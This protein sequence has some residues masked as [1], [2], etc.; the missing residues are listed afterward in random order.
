MSSKY[1]TILLTSLIL[2]LFSTSLFA[3]PPTDEVIQRLKDE[4]RFDE[5]VQSM[6]E[7]RAKGV[8]AGLADDGKGQ[9]SFA[10]SPNSTFRVLVILIDFSNKP[11]TAG[12]TAGSTA[13]FDSLLFSD[14][15]NPTGSMKEFY[16]ENSYGNFVLEGDVTGWYTAAETSD[17]YTNFCDGSRG[18]GS[19]PNNARKL[20]EEA[21]DAADANVDFSLY[22]NDGNGY[23]DG[24]FVVHSGTGYEESGNN[25]EIHSHQW[26]INPRYKDGVYITTYSIE[27]EESPS[28]QGLVPIGVFCHEFGHVLGL[29]DLYDTDYSSS[30]A[31]KWALMA[32]GSYNGQSRTPSQ[33][34]AWSKYRLGWLNLINL[35]SNQTDVEIPAVE[36][37]PVAYRLWKN[38]Q[39]GNE[40]F[41]VEN[42]QRTGFDEF[43]PSSGLLIWHIDESVG[44]NTNDW[45]PKVMLEQADGK[46][47]LQNGSNSGDGADAFP[48]GGYAPNFH[49]KTNPGSKSYLN[50][51]SQVAA[52]NISSP[53]SIM[54][55][56]LDVSWSRPYLY[57]TGHSFSDV[58]GGDGDGFLEAGETI[59]LTLTIGN[60]W[61]NAAAATLDMTIDDGTINITNGSVSLGTIPSGGS[62]NNNGLPLVFEIPPDYTP[63]IDS[64][65]LTVTSDGGASVNVLALEE[66]VGRPAVLL[67]DD[68]NN[69]NINTFYS[70]PLYG[71]RVPYDMWVKYSSGSPTLADLVKYD[72]VIWFT[73]DY[74]ANP[75]TA[76]DVTVLEDF[77]DGGGSLF[78]SGQGIAPE[79]STSYPTFLS[80][81]LKASYLSTSFIPILTPHAGT[82]VFNGLNILS[83]TG[84]GGASNQTNPDHV[85][86]VNGGTPE[87]LYY[88]GSDLAAVSYSGAHK[89]M[90]FSFGFEAIV[91]GDYRFAERDTVYYRIIDFLGVSTSTGYPE[92]ATLEVGPGT[93]MNLTDHTP[94]IAWPYFDAGGAPQQEYHVQVG[95]DTDWSIAEMW[96]HGPI[97]G[98]DTNVVYS[99][100]TLND[101]QTYQV[102]VRAFNGTQWSNWKS[103]QFRMNSVP[104]LPTG[105][106]PGNLTA[107]TSATPIL[108]VQNAFDNEFDDL[109]YDYEVYDDEL[110]TSLV[111]QVTGRPEGA[112]Q[113][114]WTV[115]TTLTENV[116]YYWRARANDGYEDG[117]WSAAASFWV[118]AVNQPPAAFD[119][120]APADSVMMTEDL[121]TYRWSRSSD[122]DLYD[123]LTY[124]LIIANNPAFTAA[125]TI[126]GLNDSVYT[127]SDSITAGL[128][129]YWKVLAVDKFGGVTQSSRVFM[130]S[131]LVPGDA[132]LDGAVDVG[133]AVV[134]INYVFRGGAEPASMTG[135]DVNLDCSVDVGDAVYLINYIFRDGPP[136]HPG[137]A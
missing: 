47:D 96:D 110:L 53:D 8:D 12:W 13:N 129:Y 52:W 100:L 61:K 121:V 60:D 67:V 6:A 92:V 136:P 124:R 71:K 5:F 7:A 127:S 81:Y 16:I 26:S 2:M 59:E 44:G 69:D 27:P 24:I 133:D 126:S 94:N 131:T 123:S 109:T 93:A 22:D 79:M 99:G 21:V 74:R 58:A 57:I 112:T 65:Y 90:F 32:S 116:I 38:G 75:L 23:V 137:C 62:V 11:Y 111:T 98:S 17:Y 48:N 20:V 97:S 3:V 115:G 103:G 117:G 30:G 88:G 14:G 118:N 83:I 119:L 56:D 106:T 77:M 128:N 82:Q 35:T 45:H 46:F 84:S 55:A 25:C 43:L 105:L 130:F 54:T 87:L 89:M 113:S 80:D 36:W 64:F 108:Q 122:S 4:G 19:Y 114:S 50:T 68:D 9:A 78:L 29:P 72:A 63:R 28:S 120:I 95:T 40:Y 42:R 1:F 37:N 51:S 66:N 73:G 132:N 18:M 34:I 33:F 10:S 70:S 102:R 104:G 41:V 39:I 49:D 85:S 91:K 134:I 125:D 107:V 15:I 31:G 76:A 135:A 86:A 101:G